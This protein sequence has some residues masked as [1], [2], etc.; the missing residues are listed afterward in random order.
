MQHNMHIASFHY[1]R[2]K[3]SM[4]I[5][6]S[7][8]CTGDQEYGAKFPRILNRRQAAEDNGIY[9]PLFGI[10]LQSAEM[11]PPTLGDT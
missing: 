6:T 3:L 2:S 10:G 5:K 9:W 7:L 4:H 1:L 11:H 8:A